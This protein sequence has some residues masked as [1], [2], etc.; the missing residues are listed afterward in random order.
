M[1]RTKAQIKAELFKLWPDAWRE[2]PLAE[3]LT[4]MIAAVFELAESKVQEW[5]EQVFTGTADGVYLDDIG[6]ELGVARLPGESDDDYRARLQLG[7]RAVAPQI[8]EDECNVIVAHYLGEGW[9]VRLVEPLELYT[10]A[11]L[12]ADI[13]GHITVEDHT[14]PLSPKHLF[15][16]VMPIWPVTG[17]TG[18]AFADLDY[19]EECYAGD[20]QQEN[21]GQRFLTLAVT[22]YVDQARAAGVAYGAS[23]VDFPAL[24]T[25][26]ALFG[27]L[28]VG[29]IEDA[30]P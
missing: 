13:P 1:A 5:L 7:A 2:D 19:S 4:D 15:W 17:L 20:S 16:L 27:P 21:P 11:D 26:D 6:A 22:E 3:R 28:P 10:D 30:T 14:H 29:M 18:A 9:K 12:Y 24:A 23:F 25:I 8:I